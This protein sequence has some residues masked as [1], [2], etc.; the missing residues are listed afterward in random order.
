MPG[1][2]LNTLGFSKPFF[3]KTEKEAG[4][5]PALLSRQRV[6]SPYIF[7]VLGCCLTFLI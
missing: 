3:V 6:G 4:K 5:E 1:H 7:S 2:H